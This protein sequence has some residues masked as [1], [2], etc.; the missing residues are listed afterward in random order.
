MSVN[1][2]DAMKHCAMF[3][4]AIVS[5]VLLS[6]CNSTNYAPVENAWQQPT[7]KQ[8]VYKVQPGDTLY[9]IAWRYGYDYRDI[10]RENHIAAP[11]ELHVGE[12][13]K[14]ALSETAQPTVTKKTANKGIKSK[15][16]RSNTYRSSRPPKP[17]SN[18]HW[19]WPAKGKIIKTFS[20]N[21]LDQKGID[22]AGSLGEPVLATAKGE[23]VYS[24]DGI[25]G[26]GNLIIVKHNEEYLSAYAHNQQNLVHEG[27]RV[28]KGQRIATMGSSGSNRVALHFE[29][30]QAG[31]PVDPLQYVK[32]G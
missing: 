24:G 25:L 31:K 32:P 15:K 2:Q 3:I 22:I 11:Y 19:Q 14:L 12:S 6:A 8:G 30:R 4:I 9:S 28:K 21:S 16:S 26:Y 1:S 29:I 10:A 18:A 23:V 5:G 20:P 13:L 7:S 27:Q 17:S